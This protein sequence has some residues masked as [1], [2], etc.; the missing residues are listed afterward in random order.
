M[1]IATWNVNSLNVR[2]PHVLK[3][4][5]ENP[6]DVLCVQET[7]MTD[8]KFPAAAIEAAG[9]HV[10][11]SG[12]KTYNGVAILSKLPI[13]DVVKNNPHYEDAQQRILAATI[14][15]VRVVCAYVPN[16]QAVGTDKYE[17]KLAWLA[18]FQQWLSE[19]AALH[20]QLAVLG[21]YNI[22][23]EDRDVHDPAAWADQ[24]LVSVPERAALTRLLEL[25]LQDSFRLFDQAEKSFSWWDY[26][27]LGFRLNKGLRIDHILLSKALVARCSACVI[28]RA[29]RKWEQPSDHA[30][31]IA[32]LD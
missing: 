22:A 23:P 12:Q 11:F 31:V 3:W 27:A 24:V 13:S 8:D 5:E 19:E 15:G 16:G 21:D 29:P 4:L 30:P 10:V 17:Y 1:K 14:D 18:A 9:Y 26:R 6:V 2:L 32:T 20:P 28:D 7:K 25:G